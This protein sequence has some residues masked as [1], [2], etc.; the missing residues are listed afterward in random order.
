MTMFVIRRR[1]EL[2]RGKSSVG[3][4]PF[5]KRVLGPVSVVTEGPRIVSGPLFVSALLP[6]L[7]ARLHIVLE[8]LRVHLT[9]RIVTDIFEVVPRLGRSVTL[10]EIH[11]RRLLQPIF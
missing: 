9:G 8:W 2:H 10:Q 3:D 7:T 6:T 5:H 4:L 11:R 1:H